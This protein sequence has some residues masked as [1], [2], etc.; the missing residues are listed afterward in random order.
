MRTEKEKEEYETAEP[1]SIIRKHKNG[2]TF[3]GF[4]FRRGRYEDEGEKQYSILGEKYFG[5][6]NV[7]RY[8]EIDI[9]RS[10][11]ETFQQSNRG[12]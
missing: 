1:L 4:N 11:T 10:V 6:R 5:S 8:D 2:G 9:L 7:T 12:I 3:H